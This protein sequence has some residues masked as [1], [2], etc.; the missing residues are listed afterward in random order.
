MVAAMS[1]RPPSDADAAARAGAVTIDRESVARGAMESVA[2]SGAAQGLVRLLSDEDRATSLAAALARWSP[3]E[4]VWLFGYGSLLWNPTFAFVERRGGRALGYR[5]SYCIWLPV[6]RGTAENPGLM[7]GLEAGGTCD[8]I[9]Y[10]I[11][12]AQVRE[13]LALVWKREMLTGSYLAQWVSVDTPAGQVPALTFVVDP[14]HERRVAP[15]VDEAVIVRH[16]ATAGGAFGTCYEYLE[17]TVMELGALGVRD[18]Y[19]ERLWAEVQAYREP[20]DGR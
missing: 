4:D 11:A 7:L 1:R 14:A 19:L 2:A 15:D 6:G 3:H 18:A 12:A 17:R 20:G 16:L 13:E 5:R 10:R 8:G 9:A